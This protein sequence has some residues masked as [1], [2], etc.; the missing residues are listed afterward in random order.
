MVE[1]NEVNRLERSYNVRHEGESSTNASFYDSISV[2][3]RSTRAS[4]MKERMWVVVGLVK[5][6][7]HDSSTLVSKNCAIRVS[8]IKQTNV[9][10]FHRPSNLHFTILLLYICSIIFP[11]NLYLHDTPIHCSCCFDKF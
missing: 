11:L 5:R 9:A 7:D 8:K 3:S 1:G 6:L 2:Y 4:R 10:Q